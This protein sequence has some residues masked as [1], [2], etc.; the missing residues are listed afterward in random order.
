MSCTVAI[1]NW[2]SGRWLRPCVE[3]LLATTTT[4][5]ILVIDNA[6]E[7]ASLESI[8]GFRNRV[9]LVQNSV[10]RGF[11]AAVNQAFHATTTTHVLILN[12]DVRAMPGAV[13]L[14]EEFMDAQPRVAAVGGYVG[15]RY[16]P[17]ALP[18]IKSLVRENLGLRAV[19]AGYDRR[20][21]GGP[22]PRSVEQP[23]AAALMVR[24]D[25]HDDVGG[26]DEQ[27]YPAWYEDVDF[28]QRLKEKGWEVYFAPK[29]EFLHEGGYSAET[30]GAPDFMRS[31]YS[32][33]LRYARKHFGMLGT[34]AVRASIAAGMIG[35]MIGR[36]AQ[37]ARYGKT[38]IGAL[39]GMSGSECKP[40]RAKQSKKW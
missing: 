28:C 24:R 20:G 2:N 32:N 23:A 31:Y 36:P 19:G 26:F 10:N 15:D 16:L 7:D 22:E 5:D 8:E 38:F 33:Q 1:I 29:A 17:K 35:R 4:A 9:N 25:A 12:P 39:K 13:Q 40:D 3:S 6:S 37:A 11:A 27:F 30:M 14:L 34:A 21:L 18:S